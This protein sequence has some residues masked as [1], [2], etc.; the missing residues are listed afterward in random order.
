VCSNFWPWIPLG[1][2]MLGQDRM[3][4]SSPVFWLGL[5]LV[6]FTTLLIDVTYKV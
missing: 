5:F 1:A 3:V 6:P 2:V 4:F